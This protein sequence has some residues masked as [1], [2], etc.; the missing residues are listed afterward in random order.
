LVLD[1][2]SN[3]SD[4]IVEEMTSVQASLFSFLNMGKYIDVSS[5]QVQ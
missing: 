5:K 2:S 4:V 1:K 3:K